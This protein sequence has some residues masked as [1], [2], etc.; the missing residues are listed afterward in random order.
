MRGREEREGGRREEGRGEYEREEEKIE[1]CEGGKY[2]T[3]L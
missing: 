1:E 2:E 3:E